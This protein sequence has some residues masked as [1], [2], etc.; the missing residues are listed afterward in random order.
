MQPKTPLPAKPSPLLLVARRHDFVDVPV[1]AVAYD[2]CAVEIAGSIHHQVAVGQESV[3]V[4]EGVEAVE[5][6]VAPGCG[7]DLEDDAAT[8]FVAFEQPRPESRRSMLRRKDFRLD[9][10]ANRHRDSHGAF[11]SVV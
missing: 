10:A 6:P 11:L 1:A 9:R 8:L 3:I 5:D 7:R 4:L 2:G